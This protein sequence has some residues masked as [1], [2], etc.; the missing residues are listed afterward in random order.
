[1]RYSETTWGQRRCRI[2]FCRIYICVPRGVVSGVVNEC[3][4]NKVDRMT[5]QLIMNWFGEAK[6]HRLPF[7]PP[8]HQITAW[9]SGPGRNLWGLRMDRG[10]F[11]GRGTSGEVGGFRAV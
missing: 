11:D 5:G 6:R 2:G 1:M 7:H 3:S 9:L 10:G 8:N 4:S